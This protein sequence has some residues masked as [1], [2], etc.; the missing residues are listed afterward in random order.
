MSSFKEK[1]FFKSIFSLIK[2]NDKTEEE[3]Q[4]NRRIV[5]KKSI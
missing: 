1:G 4:P 5:S 2:S 3:P